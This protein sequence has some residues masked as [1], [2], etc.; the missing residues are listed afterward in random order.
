[1]LFPLSWSVY[2]L[3]VQLGTISGCDLLN[4]QRKSWFGT[5]RRWYPWPVSVHTGC[6]SVCCWEDFLAVQTWG[7]TK[8]LGVLLWVSLSWAEVVACSCHWAW[9]WFS[10]KQ[11]Q[12]PVVEQLQGT[13]SILERMFS[14]SVV[15][16]VNQIL[17]LNRG[18][19]TYKGKFEKE[20]KS[21]W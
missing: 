20:T 14:F 18:R 17:L 8:C 3:E 2:W 15:L 21:W 7:K 5:P 4:S 11:G 16:W 12:P 1:M 13:T 6:W 19:V 9:K 10:P